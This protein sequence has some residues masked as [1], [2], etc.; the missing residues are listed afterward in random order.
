ME[1]RLKQFHQ[2]INDLWQF[3]KQ[4]A[5]VQPTD[6]YWQGVVADA[7]DLDKRYGSSAAMKKIILDV[8]EV[9]EEEE[10]RCQKAK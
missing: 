1:E 4:N 2:F 3:Y 8:I 7:T 9:L 10:K 5:D 6:E